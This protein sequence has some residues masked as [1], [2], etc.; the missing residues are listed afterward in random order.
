MVS[1]PDLLP[2]HVFKLGIKMLYTAQTSMPVLGIDQIVSILNGYHGYRET[3][4]GILHLVGFFFHRPHY[5]PCYN[6]CVGGV[7]ATIMLFQETRYLAVTNV[8]FRSMPTSGL[9]LSHVRDIQNVVWLYMPC[10]G[11]R[12]RIPNRSNLCIG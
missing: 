3:S 2:W 4:L 5:L 9:G 8:V 10:S 11:S 6:Q 7:T 1:G 12:E